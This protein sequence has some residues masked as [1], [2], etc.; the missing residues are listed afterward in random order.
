ME[1]NDRSWLTDAEVNILEVYAAETEND[2]LEVGTFRGGTVERLAKFRQGKDAV[3]SI[4][5]YHDPA[6]KHHRDYDPTVIYNEFLAEYPNVFLLVGDSR[7]L[8]RY[9]ARPLGLLFLDGGHDYSSVSADFWGF[10]RYVG[11][12]GYAVL[13][14]YGTEE[15]VTRLVDEVIATEQWKIIKQV[16]SIAVLRRVMT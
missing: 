8:A 15:A 12:D 9:W 2:I 6:L 16:D 7:L 13:H 4:D 3:W 10:S 5:K 14:D 1:G 11:Y